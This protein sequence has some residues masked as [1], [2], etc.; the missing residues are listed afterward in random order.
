[1]HSLTEDEDEIAGRK[2][3]KEKREIGLE[4][5][6]KKDFIPTIVRELLVEDTAGY[7]EMML[8]THEDFLVIPNL[9]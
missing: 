3:K 4:D 1:M 8:M 5:L 2:R 7:K 9:I 6:R